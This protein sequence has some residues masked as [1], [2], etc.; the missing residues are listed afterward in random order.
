MNGPYDYIPDGKKAVRVEDKN[1]ADYGRWVLVDLDPT[2]EADAIELN[3]VLTEKNAKL[4]AEVEN[5]K[6]KLLE[7]K[8]K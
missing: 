7:K 1:S 5:L 6:I 4:E 8:Q 2:N 3:R